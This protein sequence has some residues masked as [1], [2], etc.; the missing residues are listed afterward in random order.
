MLESA[1]NKLELDEY[2]KYARKEGEFET[3]KYILQ[4]LFDNDEDEFNELAE[5]LLK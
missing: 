5:E 2:Y 4:Y 3:I 1:L